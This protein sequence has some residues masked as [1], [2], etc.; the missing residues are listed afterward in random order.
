MKKTKKVLFILKKRQIYSGT[1]YS[2]ASSGLFNSANFVNDMLLK[3]KI[4]TKI[5]EV[6]DNNEIDKHVSENKPDIVIIEALWVVPSKFEILQKLHPKVKWIIRLHSELPFIANEGIAIE[7]LKEYTNYSNVIISSNSKYFI[8]SMKP[9]IG[10][11]DYLPNYYPITKPVSNGCKIKNDKV[12]NVGLFGAIRPLKNT[13][14]QAVAAMSYANEKRKILHLHINAGRIEQDGNNNLKNIRA[15]FKDTR[16]SLIEH[17]WLSHKEFIELVS[18]MDVGL[19][20]SLSETYNIVA[21][22]FVNQEVPIVTSKEIVFVSSRSQVN[23]TKDANE[24]KEKIK[25]TLS[26]SRILTIINKYFLLKNSRASEIVWTK[27][28]KK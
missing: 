19:Q 5:V 2:T 18:K 9:L 7:W 15:L 8:E 28:L 12:I 27:Y 24:I 17:G 16:H 6:I 25:N 21:A 22:D 14:T 26:I 23:I 10:K 13:L 4:D 3:N 20:V 1:S 11:I